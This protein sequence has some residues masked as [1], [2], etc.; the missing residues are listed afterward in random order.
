MVSVAVG[1]EMTIMTTTEA[2]AIANVA[3]RPRVRSAWIIAMLLA[4]VAAGFVGY[5]IG[6]SGPQP[7]VHIEKTVT[8][9]ISLL[10]GAGDA[11]CVKLD[12]PQQAKSLGPPYGPGGVCRVFAANPSQKLHAGEK[13]A[14]AVMQAQDDHGRA[15]RHLLVVYLPAPS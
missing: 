13:V 1:S 5:Q 6:R 14:V 12:H 8:G 9:T 2:H 4:V 10:N 11:G 7:V 3:P 15:Y